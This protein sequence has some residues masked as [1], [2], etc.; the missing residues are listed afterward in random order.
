[1]L[2]RHNGAYSL[3][4]MSAALKLDLKLVKVHSQA[5]AESPVT[6]CTDRARD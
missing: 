4:V 2:L 6:T 5:I 3:C 1:M